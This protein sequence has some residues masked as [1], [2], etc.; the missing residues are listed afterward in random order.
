MKEIVKM[1]DNKDD[2]G[3]TKRA[4]KMTKWWN[5]RTPKA[6]KRLAG[7]AVKV[8]GKTYIFDINGNVTF[9]D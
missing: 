4:H 3:C 7:K 8:L 9:E 6:K 5:K 1:A 2:C